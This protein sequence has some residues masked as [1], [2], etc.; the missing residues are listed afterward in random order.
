MFPQN[1]PSPVFRKIVSPKETLFPGKHPLARHG[2]NVCKKDFAL[3]IYTPVICA[4][5]S[6][7]CRAFPSLYKYF[8]YLC[9]TFILLQ[10]VSFT[11]YILLLF[12]PDFHFVAERFLRY[13]YTSVICARLSFC[14]IAF[15]LLYIYTPVSCAKL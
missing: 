3:C 1:I 15:P 5:L 12:V 8:C 13:I 11:I 10:S 6:F 4:R 7:C 14:C 2:M 9:Q